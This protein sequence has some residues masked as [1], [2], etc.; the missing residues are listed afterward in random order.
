[1]THIARG[2][3]LGLIG[4]DIIH[5]PKDKSYKDFFKESP[6]TQIDFLTEREVQEIKKQFWKHKEKMN[7]S[8]SFVFDP[9]K[10]PEIKEIIKPKLDLLFPDYVR[11]V[12]YSVD[13]KL[14]T[15]D[16][17]MHQKHIIPPHTDSIIHVTNLVPY[18]DIIIP[19]EMEGKYAPLY[20]CL[21]RFYGRATSFRK[22]KMDNIVALYSNNC[23]IQ[24]YK[25]YGVENIQEE[26]DW[27]FWEKWLKNDRFPASCWEGFSP[28]GFFDWIPGSA[29]ILDP[30][31][32]HGPTNYGDGWKLGLTIR[33]HKFEESYKPDT[34]FSRYYSHK[35]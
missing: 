34:L 24:S 18:K 28:E 5:N 8:F 15:S 13:E 22:G 31:A 2:E 14:A 26:M 32:I 35:Y 12:D 27:E 11:Y 9:L 21:Q 17:I 33:I 30:S 25:D 20:T 3:E 23:R 10:I 6:T 29:I 7:E 1:M 4:K 19:L 16:F